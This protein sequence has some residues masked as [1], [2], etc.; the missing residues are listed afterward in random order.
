MTASAQGLDVSNY[1]GRFDWAA[2]ITRAKTANAPL[3]FGITRVTQGLGA[4]GTG[5]PDPDASWDWP[6]ITAH[7]LHR[8]GYHFLDPRLDGAAQ[9]RYFVN[10]L[11]QLG[12]DEQAMLWLDNETG[13]GQP[14]QHVA[15]CAQAF[16]AE[17]TALRPRN[18]R[19]VY[20]FINFARD[21]NCDGLSGYPL[22]LAY[23]AASAPVPPPPWVN[24]RFWQWGARNGVDAD[25]FNGTAADLAA[26]IGSFA[27]PPAAYV[28]VKGWYLH[29]TLKQIANAHHTTEQEL[30]VL[31]PSLRKWLG[32]GKPVHHAG[33]IK[34]PA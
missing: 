13:N 18:P 14:P 27:P 3:S 21:G 5:S 28:W 6:Q 15:G 33:R 34:V 4:G 10:R 8:G 19:G 20:T 2:A 12:L 32:T 30:I 23:P 31:N 26:W 24:W 7:G 1:Q 16:M 9:A 29:A 25:A 17:L 11:G 22:W